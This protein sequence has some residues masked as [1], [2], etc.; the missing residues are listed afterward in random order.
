MLVCH[1]VYC[2]NVLVCRFCVMHG[3]LILCLAVSGFVLISH[4][5]YILLLQI[6]ELILTHIINAF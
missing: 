2:I 1:D 6:L 3:H 5:I 4:L